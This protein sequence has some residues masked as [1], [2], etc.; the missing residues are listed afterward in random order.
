M[1]PWEH[2][3]QSALATLLTI[4]WIECGFGGHF[5][6]EGSDRPCI[7]NG[8][9]ASGEKRKLAICLDPTYTSGIFSSVLTYIVFKL[10][11]I[12][13]RWYI[14]VRSQ[15]KEIMVQRIKSNL[16]K[17]AKSISFRT[18]VETQICHSLPFIPPCFLSH[19]IFCYCLDNWDLPM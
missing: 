19:S 1:T 3:W 13:V 7:W 8:M 6:Q 18:S 9:G 17:V 2:R 11:Q 14:Q 16:H 15:N 4:S 10:Q 5:W 12:P